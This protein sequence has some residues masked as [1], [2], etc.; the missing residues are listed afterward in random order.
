MR[1]RR[2]LTAAIMTAAAALGMACSSPT[3]PAFDG[4]D[5]TPSAPPTDTAGFVPPMTP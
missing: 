1:A 5:V 2:I 4:P 3:T